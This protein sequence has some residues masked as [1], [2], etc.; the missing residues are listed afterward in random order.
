MNLTLMED[1]EVLGFLRE[2]ARGAMYAVRQRAARLHEARR[3]TVE[4]VKRRPS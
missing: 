3:A 1:D 4:R 2:Q